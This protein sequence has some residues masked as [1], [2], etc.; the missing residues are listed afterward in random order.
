MRHAWASELRRLVVVVLPALLGGWLIGYPYAFLAVALAAYLVWHLHRLARL[1]RSLSGEDGRPLP[2]VGGLWRP[3]FDAV[4]RL[5][6]RSRKRKQRLSRFVRRFREAATA[7]PDAAVVLGRRSQV[8]WC[9]PAARGLLGLAWPQASGEALTQLVRDPMLAEYLAADDYS[10]AVVLASPVSKGRLLSVQVTAFR[11]KHQ[12]LLIARD[13]TSAYNVDRVRRDFVANVSHELR[14][15]LTVISGFLETLADQGDADPERHRSMT[16]MR[17]QAAR[18]A[19]LIDDL[20]TLSRLELQEKVA[21]PVP[22]R[23]SELLE[24]IVADARRV[25]GARAHQ[26]ELNADSELLI[27]GSESELRSAFSNLV[28]N[29]VRHTPNHTPIRVQWSADEG[30]ARLTVSDD[31]PGIPARHIP[32]LTERFYRV[33]ES[34]SRD[35]G[36]T[37]LGLA[38]VKH[39]LERHGGKLRIESAIGKGSSFIC[40][41]PGRAELTH[42]NGKKA[43]RMQ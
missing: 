23:V 11:K 3:V 15:P 42:V 32:R 25:S 33:D 1:A 8:Q 4:A 26:V 18:M 24:S 39:V 43:V 16:L 13:I 29:A 6:R 2:T 5:R 14:T 12:R 37:G 40:A 28:L 30:G 9:N 7:F 27:P 34:R 19:D 35:T 22:I 21:E 36:G 41:F 10:R 31:G 38:I 20:L 17:E